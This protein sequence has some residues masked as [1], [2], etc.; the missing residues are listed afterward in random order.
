[1][2][3]LYILA[4]YVLGLFAKSIKLP[5][6]VGY[7]IA[8]FTLAAFGIEGNDTLKSI[9]DLGVMILLFTVGLK[10]KFKNI[11]N[12]VIIGGGFISLAANSF[13]FGALAFLL[14]VSPVGSIYLG[15]LLSFSSTVIAAKV[16]DDN[17]D[18]GSYYGRI[19]IGILIIQDIVA[20]VLLGFSGADKPSY[21]ALSL[22]ALPLLI[23]VFKAA[24]NRTGHGELLLVFG[25]L[26][27]FAGAWIFKTVGLSDKLGAL[28]FG[29]LIAEQKKSDELGKLLWS[30]KEILLVA[31]FLQIGLLG[32]PSVKAVWFALIF[33]ALLPLKS[34]IYYFSVK[35]FGLRNRTAFWSSSVL[36]CYSE[37]GLIAGASAVSAGL[38]SQ[39]FLSMI[40]LLVAAS[41]TLLG[42]FSRKASDIFERYFKF[43]SVEKPDSKQA[44]HLPSSIGHTQ[45]LVV[46][47]GTCGTSTY[48]FL[49]SQG[50]SVLGIDSDP[51]VILE[52]RN[53]GRRVVYANALDN[54]F[55]K[56]CAIFNLKG[57]SICLPV[58]DEKVNAV[59]K[60]RELG[61][62]GQ[63]DSYCYFDDEADELRKA[64]ISQLVSP[65]HLTGRNLGEL[66]INRE[67]Q[68]NK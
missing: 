59:K 4:A 24:I 55:W 45:F 56:N 44:D 53:Q 57:I 19:A 33:M 66:V 50:K 60:I 13:I 5:P 26:L 58:V 65:L 48:D 29:I 15:I 40:A 64:G 46:G 35:F 38:L 21:W 11:L 32:L 7:L 63:I 14:G 12:P 23:P 37:F 62:S 2:E 28:V 47:M 36:F 6:L 61:F 20:V 17:D 34:A 68:T 41:F 8:G 39:D 16:L 27:A 9:A 42:A 67:T 43:I 52:H 10:I 54:S 18:L 3:I 49:K 22:L 30:L 25:V 1:M 51:N 31:F